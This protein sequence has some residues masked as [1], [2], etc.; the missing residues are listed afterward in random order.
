MSDL[1]ML[2]HTIMFWSALALVVIAL[3][4]LLRYA[5]S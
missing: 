2:V 5:A 4:V 3:V 1:P